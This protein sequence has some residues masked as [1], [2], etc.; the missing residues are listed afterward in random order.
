MLKIQDNLHQILFERENGISL[1]ETLKN[2]NI[3]D[4]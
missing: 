4:K 1:N 3:K 2:E